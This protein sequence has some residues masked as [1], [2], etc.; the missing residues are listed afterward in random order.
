M[1]LMS[2][3]W[4]TRRARRAAVS[5]IAP[6]TERSR[7]RPDGIPERI[8][9][10]PYMVGF[11]VMLITLLAKRDI[12][13]LDSQALGLVQSEAWSEVT[14]MR[15]DLIGAEVIHLS[16]AGN[17]TFELG[18]ADAVAFDL[19]LHGTSVAGVFNLGFGMLDDALSAGVNNPARRISDS[20]DVM[21]LWDHYFEVAMTMQL[22]MRGAAHEVMEG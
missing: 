3:L 13:A 12:D 20:R 22:D 14:G 2:G 8:W 6:L 17:K 19:A 9:L 18:C 16:A 7:N 5:T 21:A 10:E 11:L 1:W 15:S 4:R